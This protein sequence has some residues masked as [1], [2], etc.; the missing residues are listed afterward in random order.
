[1]IWPDQEGADPGSASALSSLQVC[2]RGHVTSLQKIPKTPEPVPYRPFG[3]G[4][5]SI[6]PYPLLDM[7]LL[8]RRKQHMPSWGEGDTTEEDTTEKEN[9]D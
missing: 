4:I 5:G 8:M 9:E 7:P 2:Q 1:M 3:P 6:P